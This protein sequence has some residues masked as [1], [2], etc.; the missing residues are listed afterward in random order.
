MR[1]SSSG[2]LAP[3]HLCLRLLSAA[4]IAIALMAASGCGKASDNKSASAAE[5]RAVK[6]GTP[7]SDKVNAG[8]NPFETAGI[9]DPREF[10]KVFN[11][12]KTAIAKGDKAEVANYILY[13]LRVNG[14]SGSE[15]IPTRREF[16]DQ[17]DAIMT[18]PVRDAVANQSFD[19]LFINYQGVM[20]GNGEV[21]FG[22]S[23]DKPQV[24]GMIAINHDIGKR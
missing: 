13:P 1:E 8:E 6:A 21:W 22:G 2:Q 18:K 15:L 9:T 10:Q 4:L 11:A 7:I 20:V 12:V 5:D 19:R 16:V 23:I 3:V 24:I 17:Y 14:A